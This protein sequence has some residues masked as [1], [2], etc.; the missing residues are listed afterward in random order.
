MKIISQF[1]TLLL[2]LSLQPAVA[3]EIV[4]EGRGATEAAARKDALADL[5]SRISVTVKSNFK[6]NQK[7]NVLT[8]NNKKAEVTSQ[9][10]VN[11]VETNSELPIL[12]ADFS[13]GAEGGQ[14]TAKV[15]LDSAKSLPLY[16]RRLDELRGRMSALN[17]RVAKEKTGS[18]Q[19]AAIMD[20][21]TLQDEFKKLNTVLSYLGGRVQISVVDEDALQQQLRAART[22]VD[23]LDLAAQLL[24]EGMGDSVVY[25]FPA[26]AG[27]SN[28]ITQFSAIMRDKL[29]SYLK[30]AQ[31]PREAAFTLLGQYEETGDGI[32]ITYRLLDD[33]ALAQ[34]TNSVHL[35]KT[36]YAGIVTVPKTTDFDQLLK[37]GVAMTGNLRAEVST[38]QGS[39]D[40][41]FQE[42]DEIE[43][44]VKLSEQGY[45]YVVGHTVKDSEKSSYLVELRE[46]EAPRKFVYFVNA[47]DAN[48]WISIGKF[49][50]GAPFGVEA[51]Q[52][53][54]SNKDLAA[55]LPSAK[56]DAASG[57]YL[58]AAA[59]QQAGIVKTRAIFKKA[60]KTA[61][62]S[63]ASLMFT[64]RA[65]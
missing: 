36:A 39:R 1:I 52:V 32:D 11:S 19:Y 59:D 53:Y 50:I 45:F 40:L 25:I 9:S 23:S 44:M 29:S 43:L 20:L 62:T 41:L 3:A 54:S 42:G 61:Q 4:G 63:E 31:T 13:L 8:V 64:T 65:R 35:A 21:L 57:L 28:E 49:Q 16:E 33:S 7:L 46:V 51:L 15:V 37:A 48:K 12:G 60:A 47:D 22:A 5:S 27:N 17:G 18:L 56:L 14:V 26:R 58:L 24:A 6:S 55:S 10:V 38:N 2:L 34:K 30:T